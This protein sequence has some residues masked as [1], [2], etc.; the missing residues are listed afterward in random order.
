MI[1][2][3]DAKTIQWGKDSLFNK[4]CRENC[5]SS[6]KRIKLDLYIKSYTKIYSKWIDDRNVRPKTLTLRRKQGKI[7]TMD[8]AISCI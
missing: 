7:F 8:L 6:C 5:I 3:K 4:W 1:F 2:S